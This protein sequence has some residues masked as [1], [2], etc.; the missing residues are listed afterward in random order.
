[1]HR[2]PAHQTPSFALTWRAS[3]ALRVRSFGFCWGHLNS[4]RD[5]GALRGAARQR[6]VH[7]AHKCNLALYADIILVC[8]L[9]PCGPVCCY[10]RQ[11]LFEIEERVLKHTDYNP[12]LSTM[13]ASPEHGERIGPAALRR[14]PA[15]SRPH[16]EAVTRLSS[17][18]ALSFHATAERFPMI[19]LPE[20]GVGG[21]C[22]TN[23][24]H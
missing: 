12:V 4:A 8:A 17:S 24:R 16:R 23:A 3:S 22:M 5:K 21:K 1:M 20:R 19:P 14:L 11:L 9:T 15:G 7:A 18:A 2:N 13:S 10:S 6:S